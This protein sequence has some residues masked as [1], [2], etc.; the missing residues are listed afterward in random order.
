MAL[1]KLSPVFNAQII[2]ENGNPANGWKINTYI[3]GTTMPAVTYTDSTGLIAQSNPIIINSLGFTQ[4][5]QIWLIQGVIYKLVLTDSLGVIKKTEDNISGVNDTAN[6]SDEWL[7]VAN[8]TFISA[9]SYSLI[10]DQTSEY[11]IGRRNKFTTNA[12]T[13]YGC[14]TA[15]LFSSGLTTV[16][17]QMDGSQI[18]D[19][20]LSVVQNSILRNNVLALPERIS[21]TSGTNTYTATVGIARLVIGDQYKLNFLNANN[22]SIPPT[23]NLDGNGFL[24]LLLQNGAVPGGGALNGEHIIRYTNLGFIIVDPIAVSSS[25]KIQPISASVAGNALTAKLN[26][27]SLDFR[28]PTLA[29]GSVSTLAVTSPI[30][31]VVPSTATLGTINTI[32]SRLVII[33]INNAGT[34]ELAIVNIAGGN[35]L[36]ETTLISTTAISAAATAANVIYSTTARTNVAFRVVGFVDST[37]ATAGTWITAPSTIQGHGGQALAAMSSMGYGQS[38][39]NVTASRSAGTTFYNTNS[40]PL[41][42][43]LSAASAGGGC[44]VTPTINGLAFP[45]QTINVT[46][47]QAVITV[48]VPPRMS[49]SVSITGTLGSWIEY[50]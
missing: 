40:K 3:A 19:I 33:A 17:V 21:V 5:G 15:S 50:I 48:M 28:S 4:N 9:S 1:V 37:Q 26:Q 42:V 14:I 18:L 47:S 6:A 20:G 46:S 2:D 35:N 38:P 27:T 34:V 39:T 32:P 30:S 24:S 7:T 13:V 23:L 22:G 10:G 12:G 49:Y 36:D 8:S 16:T 43:I 41:F 29:S 44:I 45:G 25:E 11:H 31:I